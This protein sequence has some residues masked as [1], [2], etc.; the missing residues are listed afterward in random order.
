MIKFVH[1]V[2]TLLPHA[3]NDVINKMRR[4]EDGSFESTHLLFLD[5]D[6]SG[7][8]P[9]HL[10]SMVERT[11][12]EGGGADIVIGICTQRRPP[13][14]I[15][16][17]L[18]GDQNIIL[19]HVR[20]EEKEAFEINYGGFGFTLIKTNVLQSLEEKTEYKPMWF[21][22]DRWPRDTIFKE[23]EEILNKYKGGGKLEEFGLEVLKLGTTSHLGTKFI[24]EDIGFCMRAKAEGFKIVA[25]PRVIIKHIGPRKYDIRDTIRWAMD[26]KKKDEVKGSS[27]LSLLELGEAERASLPIFS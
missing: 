18:D 8:I 13:F 12:P 9:Q 7:F 1:I 11:T 20:S 25:D 27:Q 3:R 17:N 26:Q 10:N 5:A 16:I 22:L 15:C 24:G 6:M 2:G 19:D 4:E 21:T 14:A 23:Y